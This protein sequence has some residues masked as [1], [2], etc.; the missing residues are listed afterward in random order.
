MNKY[1]TPCRANASR[2]SS[3]CRYSNAAIAQPLWKVCFAPSAIVFHGVEDAIRCVVQHRFVGLDERVSSTLLQRAA[4]GCFEFLE[5]I[6]RNRLCLFEQHGHLIVPR[7][8]RNDKGRRCHY[9]SAS[10]WQ[11]TTLTSS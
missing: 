4:R 6:L 3:A 10:L 8:G 1:R 5:P 7:F 9:N 11:A 2:I